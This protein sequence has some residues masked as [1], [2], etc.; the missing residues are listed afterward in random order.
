MAPKM[1][2]GL[3]TAVVAFHNETHDFENGSY[4]VFILS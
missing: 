1:G 2:G 3:N 4:K